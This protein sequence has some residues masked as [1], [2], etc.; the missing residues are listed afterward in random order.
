MILAAVSCAGTAGFPKNFF[1]KLTRWQ[2][3]LLPE[4]GRKSGGGKTTRGI[5][6]LDHGGCIAGDVDITVKEGGCEP[7]A[8]AVSY[9]IPEVVGTVGT[10]YLRVKESLC[11][12]RWAMIC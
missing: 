2:G 5:V 10:E 3:L 1:N 11:N 12:K 9:D 8:A 6:A 4:S 7:G